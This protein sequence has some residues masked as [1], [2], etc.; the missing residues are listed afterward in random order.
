MMLKPTYKMYA[1]NSEL[2]EKIFQL[3]SYCE[4]RTNCKEC[5]IK[6][7]CKRIGALLNGNDISCIDIGKVDEEYVIFWK[8]GDVE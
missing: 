2:Y 7:E 6:A 5:K 3:K 1:I 8:D 4:R